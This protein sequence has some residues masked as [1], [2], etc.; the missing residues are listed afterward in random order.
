MNVDLRNISAA[1]ADRP[2]GYLIDLDGTLYADGA[3]VPGAAAALG[4]LRAAGAP[5]RLVTNT[6]SRSRA[7]LVERLRGYGFAVHPD[8]LVT[9]TVAGGELARQRGHV[10][11]APFLPEAALPDLAPLDLAGGTS[12]RA[13]PPGW[14]ADAVLVG[15][16]GE[17]WTYALMQ[18][19]FEWLLG[20]AELVAL[21]RDR[22]WRKEGRLAL[23]AGPFVAGLEYAAGRTAVVAGKPSAGFFGAALAGLRI[24]TPRAVAMVGDDLW[25]DVQGAQAAGLQGWLV[26]TGKF[27]PEALASGEVVPDRILDSVADLA[28]A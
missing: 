15:D 25:S 28:P 5:F 17:R 19:A 13:P 24:P 7:M 23:D 1:P 21:S 26:R 2:S 10:R 27:R 18:E 16:V 3:A 22:Y 6:T 12:G 14:R 20:G 4:R 9:A 8:E 11:A